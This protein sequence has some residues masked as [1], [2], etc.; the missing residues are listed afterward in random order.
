MCSIFSLE[1]FI[2]DAD[3]D[4]DELASSDAW[5][6]FVVYPISSLKHR[7]AQIVA[8]KYLALFPY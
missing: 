6:E 8:G 2:S 4:H 3:P 1:T 5:E 7:K